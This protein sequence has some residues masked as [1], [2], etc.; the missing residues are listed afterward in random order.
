VKDGGP[1]GR[2]TGVLK[3]FDPARQYGFVVCDDDGR[4]LFF[5]ESELLGSPMDGERVSYVMGG[6]G[7]GRRPFARKVQRAS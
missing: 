6:L 5:P 7:P 2:R 4:D 1:N 3:W